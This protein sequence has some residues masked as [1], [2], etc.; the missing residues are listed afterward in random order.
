MLK[1]FPNWYYYFK[2]VWPCMSK[3]PKTTS[4]LFLCNMLRKKWGIQLIFYMQISMKA[5]YKLKLRF[6]DGY[7]QAFP[8]SQNSKFAISCNISKKKLEMK[9]TFWMQINIKVSYGWLQHF[10]H[11]S[12]LQGCRHDLDNVKGMVMGTIKHFQSTQ[13]KKFAM[14]LQYLYKEIMNEVYFG[15]HQDRSFYKLGYRFLMK[16][17]KHVQSNQKR[18]FVKFLQYIKRSI[19]TTF[20]FC[21]DTKHSDTLLGSS[22]V[23]CYLFLGNFG[24]KWAWPFRSWNSVIF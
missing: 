21:C 10:G 11:Q 24:Q 5:C 14:T 18:K 16:V 8:K 1:V 2:C 23:C 17:A 3:W 13:S 7:G 9:L 20:A 19:A 22:H 4:L 6:F 15:F 12:F